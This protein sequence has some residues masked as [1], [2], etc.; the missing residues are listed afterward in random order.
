MTKNLGI[1]HFFDGIYSSSP[2]TPHKADVIRYALQTS[3]PCRPSPH[4][5]DTKFDMIGAQETGI[6]SLLLPGDLEKRLIYSAIN[7]TGL[8]VPLT[9]SLASFNHTKYS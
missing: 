9:I 8:P 6:K 4:H 5:W 7:L 3:T 2:E 1:H